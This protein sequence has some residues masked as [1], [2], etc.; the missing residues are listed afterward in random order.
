MKKIS[1]LLAC[2]FAVVSMA[3]AQSRSVTGVVT[4]SED[5]QPVM[6]ASVTVKGTKLATVTDI[7]GK[8]ALHNLPSNAKTIVVSYIGMKT[9]EVTIGKSNLKIILDPDAE[10]LGEVVVTGMQKM[11]KR[12]FTGASTRLDADKAKLDGVADVSRSLEGRVAGVSVQN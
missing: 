12:L 11:D 2:L 3:I 9:K 5:E 7:D 6:G 8:F 4:S 1:L 10:V